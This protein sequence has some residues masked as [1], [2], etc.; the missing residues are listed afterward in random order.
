MDSG[1]KKNK[2][3]S[4]FMGVPNLTMDP[5]SSVSYLKQIS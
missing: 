2:R 1:E 5:V 4:D 3:I